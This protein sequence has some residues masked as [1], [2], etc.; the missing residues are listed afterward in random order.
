MDWKV[1]L[2][3]PDINIKEALKKMDV[4]SQKILFVVDTDNA[5]LGVVTDGDMR[6][7]I[8]SNGTL[9]DSIGKVYNK[10]P[11][12]LTKK[13]SLEKTKQLMLENRIEVIPIV[14]SKKRVIDA[15]CWTDIFGKR[16]VNAKLHIPVIIMAGGKGE[17]LD[18]LTRILPKPLIPIGNKPIIEVIMDTFSKYG[19]DKYY[20]SLNYKGEMVKAY[21]DSTETTHSVNYI[22]EKEFLGTVGSLK[23]ID[24]KSVDTFFVS[25]CDIIVDADYRDVL[26]LHTDSKNILTVVG[27]IQHHRIPYGII[28]FVDKGKIE[29]IQEKPEYD[30]TVN[31]GVYVVSRK[32]LDFIPDG[33]R[34][35]MTDLIRE[36]IAKREKVGVYPVSEKS[37]M[38]IGQWE[39]YKKAL[40]KLKFLE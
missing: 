1:L 29:D 6:R 16:A 30:L 31:T 27:S 3:P 12:Y 7:H 38:D 20:I 36:L 2:V 24:L 26:K 39:E 28:H 25:N 33:K 37:Y 9:K 23:L 35:D 19:V 32:V 21:F 22:W 17:R 11:S 14:D 18:P 10:K 13:Y 40:D 34:F 15:F 5:L 4:G 8:L